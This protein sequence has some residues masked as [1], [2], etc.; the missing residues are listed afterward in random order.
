MSK[1][2]SE[3]IVEAVT[4]GDKEGFMSAFQSALAAKVSDALEIKKVEIASTLVA[5]ASN[6]VVEEEV[7]LDEEV[8]Q[9]DEASGYTLKH[10]GT[11]R[12]KDVTDDEDQPVKATEKSYEIHKDGSKV[13]ELEHH[14][15]E[16]GGHFYSGNL[17]GRRFPWD[18]NKDAGGKDNAH[19]YLASALKSKWHTSKHSATNEEVEQIEEDAE[20][21]VAKLKAKH[22]DHNFHVKNGRVAHTYYSDAKVK[23]LQKELSEEVEQLEE[24]PQKKATRMLNKI[25]DARAG[26]KFKRTSGMPVPPPVPFEHK[27]KSDHNKAIG[28]ALRRMGEEV[29]QI[30]EVGDTAKGKEVLSNYIDKA[31]RKSSNLNR[32]VTVAKSSRGR[33]RSDAKIAAASDAY[34]K[35][36][37]NIDRARDRLFNREKVYKEEVQEIE[38]A[39]GES[40]ISWR[41][42]TPEE[43]AKSDKRRKVKITSAELEARAK[44]RRA[45]KS[46]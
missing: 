13:G 11:T 33:N 35:N 10:V 20:A 30:D 4:L 15:N 38:E 37:D 31:N 43:I 22:K 42:R 1:L 46:E 17:H 8:E 34:N 29:E 18:R 5:P 7:E 9:L 44:A 32:K 45:E 2:L 40:R 23:K 28:R 27:S 6:E 19:T 25:R 39:K 36:L 12:P 21:M 41:A 3:E 26:E 24:G 14:H 16:Y